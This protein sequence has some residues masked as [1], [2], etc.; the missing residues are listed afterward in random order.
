MGGLPYCE[1]IEM[2]PNNSIVLYPEIIRGPV[3]ITKALNVLKWSPTDFSK[4]M[5]S[6]ARF[7]DRIMLDE[8]KYKK[9][10]GLMYNKV[11]KMLS[12]D[13]PRFVEW[14]RSF[15]AERRKTELYDELDD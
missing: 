8:S 9:E 7:Y 2:H 1:T 11:K 12:Q 3:S 13:G 10:R 6:L 15:Y 4:A 14:V 5:R